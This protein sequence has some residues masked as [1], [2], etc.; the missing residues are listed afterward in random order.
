MSI[1]G[2]LNK[3]RNGKNGTE[4]SFQR[5]WTGR[6][7]N[8]M[9]WGVVVCEEKD[10]KW[11]GCPEQKGNR[12]RKRAIAKPQL[13]CVL[14]PLASTASEGQASPCLA[15]PVFT[16]LE[17]LLAIPKQPNPHLPGVGVGLGIYNFIKCYK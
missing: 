4:E 3:G 8:R 11:M 9:L 5:E 10:V 12:R 15:G 16:N 2:L 17:G 14:L 1:N 13:T 7:Q 6:D